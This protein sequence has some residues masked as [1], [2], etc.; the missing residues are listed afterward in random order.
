MLGLVALPFGFAA[1]AAD[2]IPTNLVRSPYD[3]ARSQLVADGWS[4]ASTSSDP[5]RCAPGFER[6]CASY[7][8]TE[9]C[10]GGGLPRCVFLWRDAQ[11]MVIELRTT[12]LET[13]VVEIVRCRSSCRVRRLDSGGGRIGPAPLS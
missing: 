10:A 7:P 6:Q 3:H 1:S 13:P 5:A 4:P 12:G 11:G 2:A 8:E 9:Y